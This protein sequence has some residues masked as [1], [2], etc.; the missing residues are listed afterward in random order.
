MCLYGRL[1]FAKEFW[2][3]VR[4]ARLQFYIRPSCRSNTCWPRW[5]PLTHTSFDLRVLGPNTYSGLVSPGLTCLPSHLITLRNLSTCPSFQREL[6]SLPQHPRSSPLYTDV[7]LFIPPIV[8]QQCPDR[9]RHLVGQSDRHY[10]RRPAFAKLL[11]PSAR[12]LSVRQYR[13]GPMN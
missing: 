8:Y 13:S 11:D 9:P 3:S 10:I 1:P 5:N 7:T 6:V 12:F 4:Q 2:C